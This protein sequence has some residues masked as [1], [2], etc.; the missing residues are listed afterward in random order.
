MSPST[1]FVLQLFLEI[2]L[3]MLLVSGVHADMF[4]RVEVPQLA[5][6]GASA[7]VTCRFEVQDEGLYSLKWYHNDAEFYRYVPKELNGPV[8][9]KPS[10][11]FTVK[12]WYRSNSLVA[13][14][15]GNLTTNATGEYKCEV[16]A[17]QPSFRTEAANGSLTVLEEALTPPVV[18]GIRS[19]YRPSD[20]ISI[21]CEARP[22]S[23]PNTKPVLTWYL[24]GRPGK[25]GI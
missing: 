3:T 19:R 9:V 10:S 5:I 16:I 17:E 7:N 21:R 20:D 11:S 4:P 6:K 18:L 1:D 14:S 24:H 8:H 25:R 23:L 2:V 15:L 22:I 13:L 12:E